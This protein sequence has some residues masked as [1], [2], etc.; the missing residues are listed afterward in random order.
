[1]HQWTRSSLVQVMTSHL[2]NTK[3]LPEPMLVYC[4]MNS[5]E[6]VSE[7]FESEF[8]HF[9]SR[10]CIW[11]CRLP[12]WQPFCPRG[13]ESAF[14][15]QTLEYSKRT[16]SSAAMILTL[17][18]RHVHVLLQMNLDNLFASPGHQQ[19]GYWLYWMNRSLSSMGKDFNNL[20]HLSVEKWQKIPMY[21]H[22]SSN[23]FTHIHF[24]VLVVN[25]GISNT[26]VLKIP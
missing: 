3:P 24:N 20:C 1:M 17:G 8:Y 13:D 10:K 2:F 23:R 11:K 25:Y 7:K 19:P 26:N 5:W 12:K 14:L 21:F 22:I 18:N 6:Q 4:Q 16:R 9:L 15:E